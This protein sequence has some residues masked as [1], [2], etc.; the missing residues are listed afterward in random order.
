MTQIDWMSVLKQ[1]IDIFVI[2]MLGVLTLYLVSL[3]KAKNEELKKKIEDERYHKYIN[4]LNNTITDCVIATNQTYVEALKKENAFTA[5]AQKEA[6][7]R[8]YNSIVAILSEDAKLY[9]E[10]ALG[11]LEGYITSKIE[12]NVVTVKLYK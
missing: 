10:A 7:T 8:T 2:P 1:V 3:I 12:S 4:L 11:D 6:F 5:E 9:L